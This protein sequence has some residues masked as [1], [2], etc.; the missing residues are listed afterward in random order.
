MQQNPQI[1]NDYTQRH[2]HTK[3]PLYLPNMTY[4]MNLQQSPFDKIKQGTKTVEMRLFDERRK[5]I[6]VGDEICFTCEQTGEK[7][8]CKVTAV[9]VFSDFA[10][11]YESFDKTQL[12]YAN[13]EMSNPDDMLQY[14][15]QQNV[16]KYGVVAFGVQVIV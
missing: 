15:T 3:V 4:Q 10:E 16:D 13:D 5:P 7:L 8:L 9:D 6:K 1:C 11:L 12:G 14:Y 2:F